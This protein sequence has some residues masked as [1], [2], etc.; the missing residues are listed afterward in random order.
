MENLPV[1]QQTDSDHDDQLEEMYRLIRT[2]TEIVEPCWF[3]ISMK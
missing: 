3:Y 1:F 2:C